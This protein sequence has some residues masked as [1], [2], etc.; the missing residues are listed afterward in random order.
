YMEKSVETSVTFAGGVDVQ[1]EQTVSWHFTDDEGRLLVVNA[2]SAT[3]SIG[4]QYAGIGDLADRFE[5]ALRALW[6]ACSIR[7]SDQVG[8]RFLDLVLDN[9]EEEGNWK[10]LFNSDV[11]GWAASEVVRGSTDLRASVSQIHLV[12]RPVD[13]LSE[14]PADVQAVIRHGVAP[15]G[16]I[17]PG[18]PPTQFEERSFFLDMDVFVAAQQSFDIPRL[19]QQFRSMHSQIDRFF[20]WTLTKDG[21]A[22]FGLQERQQ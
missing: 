17:I 12:S 8:V 21:E 5:G 18:F 3:L 9:G 14:F 7:R 15:R 10:G 16:S 11:V 22:Y 20:R 19:L 1:P 2:N 6:T 4:K 13:E